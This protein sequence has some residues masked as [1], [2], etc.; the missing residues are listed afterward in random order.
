MAFALLYCLGPAD[1]RA[2]VNVMMPWV[3]GTVAGQKST[4][5]FMQLEAHQTGDVALIAASSPLAR[6]V[7]MRETSPAKNATQSRTT[8][9]LEIPAGSRLDLKPG[10]PHLVLVGLQRPIHRGEW[11]P[12][13]LEFET[14]EARRFSVDVKA[15]AMTANA[16]SHWHKH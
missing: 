2:Q 4:V 1:C 5:V 15:E 9:R 6:S 8:Q 16:K 10:R 14:K 3:R 7:D 13:T 11:V 12:L